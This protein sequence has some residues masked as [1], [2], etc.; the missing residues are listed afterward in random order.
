MA[1]GS[2]RRQYLGSCVALLRYGTE[3][4]ERSA[5]RRLCVKAEQQVTRPSHRGFFLRPAHEKSLFTGRCPAMLLRMLPRRD[6]ATARS[7]T[8]ANHGFDP[9]LQMQ[10]TEQSPADTTLSSS[11]CSPSMNKRSKAEDCFGR[12]QTEAHFGISNGHITSVTLM[13]RTERCG[14]VE[15]RSKSEAETGMHSTSSFPKTCPRDDTDST[16]SGAA[17]HHTLV[18]GSTG[19]TSTSSGHLEVRRRFICRILK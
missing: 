7:G 18:C 4:W 14:Q 11:H 15:S 13:P 5:R 16:C 19:P 12:S 2:T 9:T 8:K 17:H 3:K 6:H 10:Y 1:D